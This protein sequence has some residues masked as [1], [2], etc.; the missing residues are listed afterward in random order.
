LGFMFAVENWPDEW[1]APKDK[2]AAQWHDT[3]P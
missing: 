3:S 2:E 1:T